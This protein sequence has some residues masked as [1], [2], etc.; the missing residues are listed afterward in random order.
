MSLAEIDK[1]IKNDVQLPALFE[2][3]PVIMR[4][5]Q[6]AKTSA[7]STSKHD[8]D[9]ITKAEY[10]YLLKYLRQFYE[11][12]VAFDRSDT[13][14]DRRV[15]REEFIKAIPLIENWGI[16]MSDHEERWK[17][18]DS[19]GHGMILFVEF[20]EWAIKKNLDLNDEDDVDIQDAATNFKLL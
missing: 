18:C 13:N 9:F 20:C 1:G 7:K 2:L 15:S 17:E 3:K 4:A 10:R 12:W 5:F 11:Y 16:N 6:A 8:D 14:H 19:D